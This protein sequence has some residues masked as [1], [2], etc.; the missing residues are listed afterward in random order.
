MHVLVVN[1]STQLH[2]RPLLRF[3][4]RLAARLAAVLVAAAATAC[5]G[6]SSPDAAVVDR[7]D[8]NRVGTL[9]T[10][11]LLDPA[12]QT[13][14]INPLTLTM[15][16]APQHRYVL[17]Q[18]GYGAQGIQVIDSLG[19][20]QQTID[21]KAAF[22]GGA[23]SPDSSTLYVSGGDRDMVY[24]YKWR[25]G[26]ATRSDS[27]V[28]QRHDS[29]NAHGS[30][31]PAGLGV[32]P[33]GRRLYVAENLGD[34][35]AVVDL[36]S[37][38][39]VQRVPTGAYPYG[40]VV[41]PRGTVLV[42]VWSAS[43]VLAFASSASGVSRSPARWSSARHPSS[44]QLS[45]NGERLFVTSGSTDRIS[46]L[47]ATNGALISELLD[48]PPAGPNEGSTPSN[49]ALSP[50]GT[51]LFVTEADANAVAVFELSATTSGVA[52][53]SG[54]DHLVGRIPTE[55]Y[56][57]A[58]A[59]RGTQLIVANSKGRGT[60]ANPVDGP[61]PRNSTLHAGASARPPGYTLNSIG[62]SLMVVDLARADSA[63]LAPLTARVWHNNRWDAPKSDAF[64]YPP[65]KH[66]I[67]VIKEN[68]TYDQMLG[69]LADGDTSLLYFDR[70]VT[71]NHHAL[72][73]RF[74]IYDRFLVNAE[75]SPDGH[76]WSTA[77]YTTD[78]LQRTVPSNYG[79][80]GRS[81]DYEGTNRGAIPVSDDDDV[82]APAHGYL[83]DA[84]SR[85]G[86]TLRNY[87]EFVVGVGG[88][89]GKE[90]TGYLGNKPVLR[91]N[92][93]DSFPGF[94]MNITDQR[95][96]DVWISELRAFDK[97]GTMPQLMIVR[98]PND[99]TS[100]ASARA[101]T[102]KAAVADNDLALGRMIDALSQT[103]FWA[104]SAVFVVEDDAQNGP[105]HVDS[106]RAPFLLISPWV[107]S[108]VVHRF[109][110]TTDAI[111]TI[112]DILGL[113]SLSQFDFFGRPLREIWRTTPDT[114]RY[115]ALTPA[116]SLNDKN[117]TRTAAAELS[118]GL[119][120]DTEDASEDELFNQ[121]L[122]MTMKGDKI[123]MPLPR[124]MSQLD[125]IR[126]R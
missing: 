13:R 102:P 26:L 10:G 6:K 75:A 122:W 77:A 58:I 93:C 70:R 101:P 31:Y 29:A 73:E 119:E 30:R 33:D 15:I 99:H 54:V 5:S 63:T 71:P 9:P 118:R 68:R 76:N 98:L 43:H 113:E 84:A 38:R 12:A 79:G 20:V 103:Q 40:V 85:K 41:T 62:G 46:V 66:V 89:R 56:P 11:R 3:T 90:P 22:V 57:S 61:G 96:A 65:I 45:A 23:F 82:N 64:S 28:L 39:V 112:E 115:R 52:N 25:D 88:G 48:P 74:G 17:V 24:V 105:D 32:S 117:P 107:Q 8:F 53:A 37:R 14:P 100:G 83:W 124:R 60:R 114:T 87:G 111:R 21:E 27:I 51:R 92:T 67:Y 120:L 50:D 80:K 59:V 42:S 18:S 35:L 95:R 81:Y 97:S 121:I 4:A 126:G 108:G 34:S 106:H 55:W 110:N 44:M 91:N 49:V 116:Q 125:L 7:A 69:D 72:A 19:A 16:A 94:N 1:T 123:P 2:R 104:S 109:V 86:I 36:S 78:Y 47:N